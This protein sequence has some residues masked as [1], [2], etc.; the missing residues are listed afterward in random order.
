MADET[1]ALLLLSTAKWVT[2]LGIV[3]LVGVSAFRVVA[4]RGSGGPDGTDLDRRLTRQ[5]GLA[6]LLLLAG[7]AARLYAQTYSAFGLDEPVTGDLMR[8][9]AEQ[10]RWGTRW[11][12]Q[13][14]AIVASVLALACLRSRAA[15]S[16]WA[17][18][19][20]TVAVVGTAP[21]TGH[22]LAYAGGAILPMALQ[23]GHL[24]AA[25][26]WIGALFVLVSAGLRPPRG[27][28]RV[29]GAI[30]ASRLVNRF[31]PFA[32][33][34][35]AVLA[36][37]GVWTAVLYIDHI[38]QLWQTTYGR[39]LLLKV[40]LFGVTASLGAYNWRRVKPMLASGGGVRTLRRSAA[41]ELLVAACVLAVTAW[42]VHLPMPHE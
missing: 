35:A 12:L 20:A 38:P 32:L 33:V 15:W 3:W 21:A 30:A 23:I 4:R 1:F 26:V 14:A 25:G 11:A 42:L 10:T 6:L 18:G 41:T 13:T 27:Q 40:G 29:D 39:V 9:V 34:S 37:T 19:A 24:M 28:P 22:A 2:D 5:T 7:A 36:G 8:L 31:S 17:L 16:W